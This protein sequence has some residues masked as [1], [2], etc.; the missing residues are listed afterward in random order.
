LADRRLVIATGNLGKQ[1]EF[2]ELFIG[3]GVHLIPFDTEV[4]ESG[5]TY[6]ANARLK[7]ETAAER[8]GT[9]SLGDDAG[10]E[11]DA[12]NGFPGIYSARI[13][14][15]QKART[16]A[17]LAK[18]TGVKRPWN[19]RF[20]CVLALAMPGRPTDLFRG[21]CGGEV[22]PEWRGEAGFGYDPIFLVPSTGKTFGEM[23]ALDKHKLSHR[24][25]AVRA[26]IASGALNRLS[27]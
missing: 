6:S 22:V 25:A 4:E 19:A 1:R 16:E 3:A 2:A 10:I 17:L 21:E 26:L 20:V 24:G 15:T 18:L 8:T 14:P 13:G 7:A 27:V 9:A 11:V 5:D 12:L 23:T